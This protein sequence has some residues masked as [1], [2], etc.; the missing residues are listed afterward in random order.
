MHFSALGGLLTSDACLS[1]KFRKGKKEYEYLSEFCLAV[2]IHVWKSHA[3]ACDPP[4]VV[5]PLEVLCPELEHGLP[6]AASPGRPTHRGELLPGANLE[7]PLAQ[8]VSE[9]G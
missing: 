4:N 2:D 9:T 8:T 6:K 5:I 3:G 7:R 1:T